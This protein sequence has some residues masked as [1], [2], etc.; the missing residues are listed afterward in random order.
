VVVYDNSKTAAIDKGEPPEPRL[1]LAYENG[2]IKNRK[3]L[4]ETPDWA[5]PIVA[6]ALEAE[7]S[8]KQ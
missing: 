6:A 3:N 1:I 4:K 2:V 5:K 8:T 7:R